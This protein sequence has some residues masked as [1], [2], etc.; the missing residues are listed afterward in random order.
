MV[1]AQAWM[2]G[3]PYLRLGVLS[4][5]REGR[6]LQVLRVTTTGLVIDSGNGVS[7][8]MTIH[9][10]YARHAILHSAGRV[11][12][13]V[14]RR[15]SPSKGTLSPP[16]RGRDLRCIFMAPNVSVVRTFQAGWSLSAP[17]RT[18]GTEMI[19]GYGARTHCLSTTAALCITPS[20]DRLAVISQ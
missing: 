10:G 18:T 11:L 9:E 19:P 13:R 12:R 7:H 1:W 20:F 3:C 16:Q 14:G 6:E 17:R 2:L 5:L 4:R 15:S 8:T